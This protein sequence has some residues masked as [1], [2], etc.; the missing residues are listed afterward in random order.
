VQSADSKAAVLFVEN[1][2]DN[3]F[4]RSGLLARADVQLSERARAEY[5]KC[6]RTRD[7]NPLPQDTGS[8]NRC[9]SVD[10]EHQLG[11]R[12]NRLDG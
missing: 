9:V 11:R 8:L 6:W 1:D 4:A 2:A 5:L 12:Q 3:S 10:G 7:P